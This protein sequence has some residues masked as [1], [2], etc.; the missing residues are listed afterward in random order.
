[1]ENNL[2]NNLE[3]NN[4]GNNNT[5]VIV[6][7][8]VILVVVALLGA[9]YVFYGAQQPSP[10]TPPRGDVYQTAYQTEIRQL[11]QESETYRNAQQVFSARDFDTAVEL[12]TESLQD[13][14]TPTQ[15][16]Q[17]KFKIAAA[18]SRNDPFAAIVL[19]KE[20][21]ANTSYP[22]FLRANSIEYIG[23]M[24]YAVHDM[25]IYNEIFKD[26]PYSTFLDE[27]LNKSFLQL[28]EY[29]ATFYPIADSELRIASWH[30]LEILRLQEEEDT[31]ASTEK[32]IGTYTNIIR[33]KL[34]NA[35][36]DL[37]R[38]QDLN[39][40]DNRISRIL[41]RKAVVLGHMFRSGDTSFSDPEEAF[42]QALMAAR[43]RTYPSQEGFTLYHY[44]VFLEHAFGED[45]RDDVIKLLSNFYKANK[46]EGMQVI[47]FLTNEKNNI[48]SIP[49]NDLLLLAQVDPQFKAFLNRL[50]WSLD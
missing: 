9:V 16:G 19:H 37:E 34:L 26:E 28:Y 20:I 6:V 36:I 35:D 13:A 12:F 49:H 47:D 23:R 17:I 32:T 40:T 22:D 29:A 33:E 41:N 21:A 45:R 46:F 4:L 5:K 10:S 31:S 15:E 1:L 48:D 18:L 7:V 42:M 44:A 39:K 30:A 25:A 43:A 50:G 14:Q 24:Y 2:E 3:G 38:I 8:V 11:T 27:D